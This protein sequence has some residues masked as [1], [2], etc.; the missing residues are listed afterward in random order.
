MMKKVTVSDLKKAPAGV[1]LHCQLCGADCSAD[2]GDYGFWSGFSPD[3]V[4][5]H[6]GRPMRLAIKRIVYVEVTT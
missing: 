1:C 4:F 6:C 5:R 3:H 2:P